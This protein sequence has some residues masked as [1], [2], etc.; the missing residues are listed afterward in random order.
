MSY[1]GKKPAAAVLTASD[2]TDGVVS[3][4]KIADNAVTADKTSYKDV[5]YRNILINGDM[6]QAQR[7]TSISSITTNTYT[8]D[9]W[10]TEGDDCTMT[11]SQDTDVPTA[12]GFTTSLKMD[13]TS[14]NASLDAGDAV[15]LSQRF[16]GQMLQHLKKGTA[17]AE[18]ITL[19]FWVK[20]SIT[21][22]F[23]IMLQDDDNSRHISKSYT[24]SSANTWEQK[25]ITFTGDTTGAFGND[26][27]R[28]L[29][30]QFYIDAGTTYTSGTLATS[31]ASNTNANRATGITTGWSTSTSNNFWL[32]GVQLEAGTSASDFE[33]LPVDV[34]L[35]RCQRYYF[36]RQGDASDQRAVSNGFA[37]TTD[38]YRG[39]V[40]FP[41]TMRSNPTLTESALE[42]LRPGQVNDAVSAGSIIDASVNAA[43]VELVA[44]SGTPYTAGDGLSVRVTSSTSAFIAFDGEL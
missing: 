31:W 44:D 34:N 39:V 40:V 16:E 14:A 30:L 11:V 28:S 1:I 24:I 18:S 22:T 41:I 6:S 8:L 26:N 23:I 7:G 4:A 33:F 9:R 20:N 3:T 19:S 17:S 43:M 27:G 37:T 36:R 42:T 32:T 13:V 21:G 12:Q 5:P 29:R 25:E 38:K 15:I 2:I 35:Q 10:T